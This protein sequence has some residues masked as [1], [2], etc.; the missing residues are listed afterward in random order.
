MKSTLLGMFAIAALFGVEKVCAASVDGNNTAVVIT[1]QNKAAS[2][3]WQ[4]LCVPVDHFDIGGASAGTLTLD[5]VLPPSLYPENSQVI[6]N[7]GGVT[8]TITSGAWESS[9][10]AMGETE[11]AL[12]TSFLFY[13]PDD[14]NTA[15]PSA[16]FGKTA[17][18]KTLA[19]DPGTTDVVF[20]GQLNDSV[21]T[22]PSG[23][24][25]LSVGNNT[26]APKSL[27]AIFTSMGANAQIFHIDH[28]GDSSYTV[29][30]NRGGTWYKYVSGSRPAVVDLGE[31]T[32]DPGEAVYFYRAA[33]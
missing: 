28:K 3:G 18:A 23:S 2:T 8:A 16:L 10:T 22:A 27:S 21:N 4:L 19:A 26:N 31:I 12:G 32:L 11:M 1:R 9:G 13:N 6:L 14:R 30:R 5:D 24:G 20:C 15:K 25:L 17:S 33:E 29:Y 7:N